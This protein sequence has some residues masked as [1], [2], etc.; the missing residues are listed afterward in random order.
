MSKVYQI[1]IS[2]D[3]LQLLLSALTLIEGNASPGRLTEV[4][5]SICKQVLKLSNI[6]TE[7]K[8]KANGKNGKA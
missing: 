5:D 4:I 3:D 8:E 2:A 7:I 6:S 1:T